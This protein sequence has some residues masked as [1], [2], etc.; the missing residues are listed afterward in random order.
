MS[1][2]NTDFI[3]FWGIIKENFIHIFRKKIIAEGRR[4]EVELEKKTTCL[5]Y[6]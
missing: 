2:T 1:I 6:L 5:R 4:K 3:H